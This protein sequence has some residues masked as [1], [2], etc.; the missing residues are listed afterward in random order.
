MTPPGGEHRCAKWHHSQ[1]RGAG[2]QPSHGAKL[3]LVQLMPEFAAIRVGHRRRAL[4]PS[5][6]GKTRSG[7]TMI[8]EI[9]ND[10]SGLIDGTVLDQRRRRPG[11]LPD[12]VGSGALFQ[13]SSTPCGFRI[14][15]FN[16][17]F[18][19]LLNQAGAGKLTQVIDLKYVVVGWHTY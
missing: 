6:I 3:A 18:H 16:K 9:M 12:L 19:W 4:V 11:C 5:P 2:V 10:T 13:P 1:T 15:K 8:S 17:G 14:N 7:Q